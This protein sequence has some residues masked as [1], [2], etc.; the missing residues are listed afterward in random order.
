MYLY[1]NES[2]LKLN[3]LIKLAVKTGDFVYMKKEVPNWIPRVHS[4]LAV[5][6]PYSL[7][8]YH[9]L[10]LE[11]QGKHQEALAWLDKVYRYYPEQMSKYAVALRQDARFTPLYPQAEQACADIARVL[12]HLQRCEPVTKPVT[13]K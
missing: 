3:V 10:H 13:N 11:R 4:E 8:F 2:L 1:N 7:A 6:R 5:Q 12:P 9:G